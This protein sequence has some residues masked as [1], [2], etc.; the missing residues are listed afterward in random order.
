MAAPK[1]GIA[2][3]GEPALSAGFTHLPYV[4]PKAPKGGILKQAVTGSFD[5]TNP[6][7]VRGQAAS[8]VRT[9]VFESLLGRNSAEPF[10]LYGLLAETID[11]NEDF[12]TIAFKLRNGAKFSDGR[13]VTSADVAYSLELL[14]ERGRPNFRNYYS[15]VTRVETPDAHTIIYHQEGA[16]RELPLILGLMPVLPKHVWSDKDFESTT[17]EPLVGSGPYVMAEISA[18]DRVSY[19]RDR[20][21]WGKDLAISKGL[22]NFDEVRFDYYRDNNASF[23]AFKK[24]LADLRLESD[25]SRWSTGYDFPAAKN[26]AVILTTIEQHSPSAASG[27][28]FNTRRTIFADPRVREAL[29]LCF[30]FEWANK[31][32]FHDLYRRTQGYY[33]NSDL[34]YAGKPASEIELALLGDAKSGIA[35]AILD[36]TY[37]TPVSDGTGHDRKLLRKAVALL[38]G[39]GWEIRGTQLVN[40]ESGMPFAFT[41]S[42]VDRAQEKIALHYQ[43]TLQ[44]IGVAMTIRVVDATEFQR[45]QQ[46]YEYDMVPAT[47]H[48]SLSPG[49]EQQFYF[50]SS[51]RTTEGTRNYPGIA[52]PAVDRLIEALL[53]A[54]SR[55]DLVAAVRALDRLLVN[56]HYIV[57]FYNS[58]GQWLARAKHI[59]LPDRRPLQGF[60]ATTAWF[61]GL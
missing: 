32:L 46:S 36:G 49:N 56:G 33:P 58:G 59:G 43:R 31:N 11:V 12:S 60:D 5:S 52:D 3:H 23:E 45:L 42:I 21:Y 19:R 2:M 30:D 13:A 48:N 7:I 9:L 39:A 29:V 51:G 28:A 47:W 15:K 61:A 25:P 53:R 50:G 57:P 16:D 10:S 17:L 35:E 24:G 40:R 41:L 27:F 14:R 22:W 20:G 54:S 8:G 4:N 55:N 34:S 1:H 6:F 44:K 37:R 38:A 26:G 18:G